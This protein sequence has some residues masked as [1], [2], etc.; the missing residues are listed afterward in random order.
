MWI[1]GS[2]GVGKSSTAEELVRRR[3]CSRH[4][5]AEQVGYMLV[6]NLRGV[7]LRDFQD[8]PAWRRLVP[9]VAREVAELTTES[10]VIVQSMLDRTYGHE[11]SEG[12][13]VR[14]TS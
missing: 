8:I 11:L 6:A 2:F 5:D 13:L 1:N 3:P 7:P 9:V 14:T 12:L 10:L 4:F